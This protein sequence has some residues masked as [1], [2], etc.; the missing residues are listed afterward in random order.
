MRSETT[1]SSQGD[2]VSEGGLPEPP[3]RGGEDGLRGWRRLLRNKWVLQAIFY[4][5]ILA[6][7]QATAVIKGEFFL[8]TIPQT[9]RGFGEIFTE[10]YAAGV[11]PLDD[12]GR[13]S[14]RPSAPD[15]GKRR[16]GH[17]Y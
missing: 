13:G 15:S 10:G 8:P 5:A 2:L 11:P 9:I 6:V 1:V 7:W 4:G 3:R 14:A 16:P 12:L 17:R